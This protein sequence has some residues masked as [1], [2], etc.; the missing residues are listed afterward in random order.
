M[1]STLQTRLADLASSFADDV[2]AAIRSASLDELVGQRPAARVLSSY[3]LNSKGQ[4][5]GAIDGPA[6]R[7]F[8]APRAPSTPR[9]RLARRSSEDIQKTLGLVIAAIKGAQGKGM[10]AE[11]IRD[12]LKIDKRELPRVLAEGLTSKKLRSKGKKRATTY[13]AG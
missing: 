9:G 5:Q 6:P 7:A 4:K 13:F 11:E 12:F 8:R 10:R 1:P 2:L 3:L